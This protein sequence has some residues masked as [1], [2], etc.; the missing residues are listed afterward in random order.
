MRRTLLLGLALLLASPTVG[1]AQGTPT[2][3]L[4]K[5]LRIG[6]TDHK[7]QVYLPA[8]YTDEQEWPVI[9]F[10]HGA[11]ERGS[12][13]TSQS[14]VGLGKAIRE[15][16]ERWPAI[17]VLPQ[18]AEGSTWVGAHGDMEMA[19]LDRTLAEYRGDRAR[20]YLTGLSMGGQGTW[21]LGYQHGDRFAAIVAICGF[22]GAGAG[23]PTFLPAGTQDPFAEAAS[24]LRGIPIQV[25][26]GDADRVVPADQSRRMVSA[27]QAAGADVRYTEFP[28][29]GHNAWDPAYALSELPA[30]LFRQRKH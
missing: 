20:L 3:F 28:G 26:H 22:V 13:G 1:P 7:Y 19:A 16:P 8:G 15:H 24:R 18:V 4:D 17:V 21:A 6:G 30:W 5:V 23:F 10:L 14:A 29:V 27:L 11:G 9:L 12:D 2:G 25:F